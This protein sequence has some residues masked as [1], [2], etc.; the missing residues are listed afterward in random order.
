VAAT[1]GH[2]KLGAGIPATAALQPIPDNDGEGDAESPP[3]VDQID[4]EKAIAILREGFSAG[5]L[6]S[7]DE[8][9]HE[10]AAALGYRRVGS[11]IRDVLNDFVRTAVRRGILKNTRQG[12]CILCRNIT[13]YDRDFL[14]EQLTA[15]MGSKWWTR[16]DL[17]Y[18][19]VTS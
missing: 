14:V 4:R 8:A 9:I 6:R 17:I 13:D 18:G 11:Q 10:L 19:M 15:G 16:E 12:L 2:D 3:P 7:R 1:D 5:D